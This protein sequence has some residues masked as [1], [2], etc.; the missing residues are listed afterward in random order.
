[1]RNLLSIPIKH[2]ECFS[3]LHHHHPTCRLTISSKRKSI[4]YLLLQTHGSNEHQQFQLQQF[5][6]NSVEEFISPTAAAAASHVG[7]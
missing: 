3:S 6:S 4:A 1:L 2:P 7:P 5:C